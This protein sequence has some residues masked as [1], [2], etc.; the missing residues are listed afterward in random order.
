MTLE[1]RFRALLVGNSRYDADPD[2]LEPLYGPPND[3]VGIRRA[4][5]DPS[6]GLHDPDDVVVLEDAT[7][8]EMEL[9]IEEFFRGAGKRDQL[10]FY[11][12]GHGLQVDGERLCLAAADSITGFATSTAVAMAFI[13][14]V[15]GRTPA[16]ATAILLDCCYSGAM[17]GVQT[18]YPFDTRAKWTLT[19]S[20]RDQDSPDAAD[21]GSMSPFTRH[22]VDALTGSATPSDVPG[23]I[24]MFDVKQ[25]VTPLVVQ[26]TG[27]QP[28]F[29]W[30]GPGDLVIALAPGYPTSVDQDR[31]GWVKS[32]SGVVVAAPPAPSGDTAGGAVAGHEVDEA[33][34]LGETLVAN[35][36]AATAEARE[37]GPTQTIAEFA[38]LVGALL[39]DAPG[40]A[41]RLRRLLR[42]ETRM[43]VLA[44]EAD[45]GMV[46]L[47]HALDRVAVFAA[48]SVDLGVDEWTVAAIEALVRIYGE[49]FGA[50][51]E[52]KP[53]N[54]GGVAPVRL[55]LAILDRV[56]AV[57]SLAVRDAQWTLIRPLVL[58]RPDFPDFTHYTNWIRHALTMA[59][60][61]NLF[62]RE[63][64]GSMQDVPALQRALEVTE[65]VPEL[66]PDS[67]SEDRILTSLCQFDFL[68]MV[69]A[70]AEAGS[71]ESSVYYPSFSRYYSIRTEPV[72]RA[73]IN[74][75]EVRAAIPPLADSSFANIIATIDSAADRE[76]MRWHGFSDAAV[77]QFVA[78]N[79]TAP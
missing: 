76:N 56:F 10:L 77:N 15:A 62:Q 17:K 1:V 8:Q 44:V 7:R 36:F 14:E 21:R 9:R 70:M 12:S 57:G 2:R 60:R 46:S 47:T 18:E 48:V 55:W 73:L 19:S 39:E 16:H 33:D 64:D 42:S 25:Y 67:E 68:A 72:A 31:E 23:F 38:A 30:E 22:V 37:A 6:W 51:G 34:A 71:L 28:Q 59:A 3:L 50:A 61:A 40:N 74:R 26:E 49:G 43:A 54:I 58:Q 65:R 35:G 24:T 41:V 53:T 45:D 13:N 63:V 27:R 66:A 4:L 52:P 78:Q 5:S 79:R 75:P 20:R 29:R 11:F 32:A 69:C